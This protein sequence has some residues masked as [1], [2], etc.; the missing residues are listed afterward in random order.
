MRERREAER[1]ERRGAWCAAGTSWLLSWLLSWL[2]CVTLVGCAQV[3][4]PADPARDPAPPDAQTRDAAIPDG[5]VRDA[6][7]PDATVR[8]QSGSDLATTDSA[9]GD[10]GPPRCE[11]F[12][13]PAVGVGVPA[14]MSRTI[15]PGVRCN[16]V[17]FR[18]T[19]GEAAGLEAQY[20]GFHCGRVVDSVETACV[21]WPPRDGSGLSVAQWNNVCDV[22]AQRGPREWFCWYL[23]D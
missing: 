11:P 14:G 3:R 8:D 21:M 12:D 2:A 9:P 15:G 13:V 20:P 4:A 23:L 10:R 17:G 22:E 6:N 18:I 5:G 7:T 1:G 19:P 16:A